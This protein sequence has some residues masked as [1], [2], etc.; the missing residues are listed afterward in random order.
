MRSITQRS[1]S[2]IESLPDI[3][4]VRLQTSSQYSSA[5]DGATQILRNEGPLAFYKVRKTAFVPPILL[6]VGVDYSGKGNPDSTAW[7]WRL[8]K[9]TIFKVIA[10]NVAFDK[11]RIFPSLFVTWMLTMKL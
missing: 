5:F 8:C 2:D 3:V 7:N 9:S 6:S 4:K 1:G 10:S 11:P